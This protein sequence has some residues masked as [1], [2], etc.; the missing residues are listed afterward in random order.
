[1]VA[2]SRQR[3]RLALVGA[4]LCALTT[5]LA[6]AA[7]AETLG[8]AIALAYQTNPTLQSQRATQRA[9]DETYVQARAGFRPTASAQAEI[10]RQVTNQLG[11]FD[12]N[13]AGV[14]LNIDQPL[15]TGGRVS[16]Q[17]TAAEADVMAGRETLRRSEIQLLQQV[18]GAYVDVR[19]DQQR[20]AISQENVAVLLR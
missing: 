17:V 10:S 15:Y 5:V 9:L 13:V 19:R 6:G 20:L 16:S 1:M 11:S 3:P 8:D 4:S 18:V 2:R 12:N 7:A 14:S